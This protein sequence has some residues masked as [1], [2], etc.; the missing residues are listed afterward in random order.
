MRAADAADNVRA[1]STASSGEE[2]LESAF[3]RLTAGTP[4]LSRYAAPDCIRSP[5]ESRRT[6][7]SSRH[8]PGQAVL[9]EN[10]EH[11]QANTFTPASSRRRP[12]RTASDVARLRDRA[13]SAAN[14]PTAVDTCTG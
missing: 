3:Q 9:P 11:A 14:P 10:D 5:S 2:P 12:S 4:H 6:R 1:A 13:S 7:S 8:P